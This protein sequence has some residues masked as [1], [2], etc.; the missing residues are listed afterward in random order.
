MGFLIFKKEKSNWL[1]LVGENRLSLKELVQK[2][3][4]CKL[5][6]GFIAVREFFCCF[7]LLNKYLQPEVL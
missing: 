4:A 5:L 2:R 7:W 6:L 3:L 1:L